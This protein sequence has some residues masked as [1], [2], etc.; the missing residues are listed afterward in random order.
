MKIEDFPK[1]LFSLVTKRIIKTIS[2][3]LEIA[4]DRLKYSSWLALLA[5]TAIGFI[6]SKGSDVM[7]AT[8][9]VTSPNWSLSSIIIILS[10]S[11][12]LSAI[13]YFFTNRLLKSLRKKEKYY[14]E[15]EINIEILKIKK[16]SVNEESITA[17]D[18]KLEEIMS[19]IDDLF[20][21]MLVNNIING[22]FLG[23]SEDKFK[24]L[25][26]SINL[27]GRILSIILSIQIVFIAFAYFYLLK[28]SV[29]Y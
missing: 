16:R 5:S 24:K 7:K 8:W 29:P 18:K 11:I 23:V 14:I 25:L 6:I 2:F 17:S 13:L 12:T 20:A 15:Q 9:F 1:E 19:K 3:E 4:S 21:G 22:E 26:K 28:A 27:K 10:I